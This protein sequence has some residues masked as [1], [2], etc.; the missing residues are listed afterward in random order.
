MLLSESLRKDGLKMV[1][2]Q[3]V[4]LGAGSKRRRNGSEV[5]FTSAALSVITDE[6]LTRH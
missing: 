4:G 5:A 1:A 3:R 2:A 6:T